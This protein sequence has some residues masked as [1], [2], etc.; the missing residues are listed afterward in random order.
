[1]GGTANG[2]AD[3]S[4]PQTF[5]ISVDSLDLRNGAVA[6]L[7][8]GGAGTTGTVNTYN[9]DGSQRFSLAP[10]AGY[11]GGV[12]AASGDVDGDGTADV[13][14]DLSVGAGA[15]A[16]GGNVKVF[17]GFDGALLQSF[18][19]FADYLGGVS[20]AAGDVDGDGRAEVFVGAEGAAGGHAKVF[21]GP[22]MDLLD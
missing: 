17:S 6:Q 14:A 21:G 3:V 9:A 8:L 16:S 12:R 13:V 7:A 22:A 15:G 5:S 1:S 2:G 19:S 11:A 10:F 18:L 4:A 20:V